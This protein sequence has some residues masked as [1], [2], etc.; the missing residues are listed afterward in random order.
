VS[1]PT[2]SEAQFELARYFAA[3]RAESAVLL[4]G[5]PATW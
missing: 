2:P 5:A 4:A 1:P 3:E